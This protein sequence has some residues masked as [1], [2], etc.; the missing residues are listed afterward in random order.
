MTLMFKLEVKSAK[1]RTPAPSLHPSRQSFNNLQEE[2]NHA[3]EI[4]PKDH[5]AVKI[6][7]SAPSHHSGQFIHG[8]FIQALARDGYQCMVT[9]CY[10][11]TSVDKDPDLAEMVSVTV[12]AV[13]RETEVAHIFPSS[14]NK[15][16]VGG[17]RD[18]KVRRPFH[19]AHKSN[20]M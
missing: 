6:Q 10:D 12:G 7:V 14:I 13:T 11:E 20:C 2:L 3:L 19:C 8:Y 17:N 16:V 18:P 4:T 15:D 1:G 5:R 9:G